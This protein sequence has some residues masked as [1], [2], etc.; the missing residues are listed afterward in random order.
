M[1][2]LIIGN[3]KMA[4]NILYVLP[5]DTTHSLDGFCWTFKTNYTIPKCV[6]EKLVKALDLVFFE[7]YLDIKK[8]ENKFTDMNVV[9]TKNDIIEIFVRSTLDNTDYIISLL[10]ALDRDVKVFIPS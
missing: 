8:Y 9:Y 2:F 1:K 5:K 6:E 3:R 10:A 4:R 7:E